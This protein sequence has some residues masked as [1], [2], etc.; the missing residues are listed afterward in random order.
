MKRFSA[1][2]ISLFVATLAFAQG[3]VTVTQSSAISDVVNNGGTKTSAKQQN[4]TKQNTATPQ[5]QTSTTTPQKQTSTATTPKQQTQQTTTPKPTVNNNAESGNDSKSSNESASSEE[6][7][8]NSTSKTTPKPHTYSK[9]P[10]KPAKKV[11]PS[12]LT[13]EEKLAEHIM[14]RSVDYTNKGKKIMTGSHKFKGWRIQI[15]NGGN[16]GVDKKK[17]QEWAAKLKK[18]FPNMPVYVHFLSPR[19]M[20]MCGN[21]R[22]HKEAEP[23]KKKLIEAGFK[24]ASIVRQQIIIE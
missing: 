12:K 11:D 9:Q 8:E 10:A 1:F 17:A 4:A 22:T 21:Y 18:Q 16:K 23:I 3:S 13:D 15:F 19:W 7:S 14:E 5:K 6:S 24:Y 2:I 20:T